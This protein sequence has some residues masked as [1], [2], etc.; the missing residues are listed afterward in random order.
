MPRHWNKTSYFEKKKKKQSKKGNIQ[1]FKSALLALFFSGLGMLVERATVKWYSWSQWRC[2]KPAEAWLRWWLL[3]VWSKVGIV[4]IARCY[5]Q[6]SG[7]GF[8]SKNLWL[9]LINHGVPRNEI[10]RQ[11]IKVCLDLFNQSYSR[12]GEQRPHWSQRAREFRVHRPSITQ[13]KGG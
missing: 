6:G 2:G 12:S 5:P 10:D 9:W 3:T 7:N 8:S 11:P 13:W 1:I 4:L